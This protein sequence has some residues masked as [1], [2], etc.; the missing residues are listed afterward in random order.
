MNNKPI[1]Y[2]DMDGVIADYDE[3]IRIITG[4]K[5]DISKKLPREELSKL[6]ITN[7]FFTN[8]PLLPNA[9]N[10][11]SFAKQ[12][13]GSYQILSAP[14]HLDQ[15]KGARE[16]KIWI[17]NFL[18]T[19]PPE[20]ATFDRDK[21]K[22]AVQEDGTP[23]VLID[24]WDYNINLW[25]QHGGIGVLYKDSN[26]ESAKKEIVSAYKKAEQTKE[27]KKQTQE[28]ILR[29]HKKTLTSEQVINYVKNIHRNYK[30]ISPIKKYS[31][32]ILGEVKLSDLSN[33]EF[34]ELDDPYGR[35]IRIN[36][37]HVNSLDPSFL[38]PIVIDNRGFVLDG[39]HRVARAH[40]EGFNKIT[41]IRPK[42]MTEDKNKIDPT[43]AL[44]CK[45][46]APLMQM[47]MIVTWKHDEIDD[48]DYDVALVYCVNPKS[49]KAYCEDGVHNSE[50][51]LLHNFQHFSAV[52]LS[53]ADLQDEIRKGN[54]QSINRENLDVMEEKARKMLG[55]DVKENKND[56][57]ES[58]EFIIEGGNVFKTAEG[59]LTQ[60]IDRADIKPT[61]VFLE[62]L[63]GLPL[64]NNILG[65]VGK[66]AS[67]GDIDVGVDASSVSKDQLA[68][69]LMVWVKK[70]HPEDAPR[71]WV[72]KSGDSV[73]F[74]TP[75]AG[76]ESKGYVQTD[77]MFTDD[78]VFQKFSMASEGDK[79]AYSGM[80]RNVLLASIAKARGMKWSYKAGL[81]NRETGE[82]ISKDPIKIAVLLLGKGAHPEQLVSVETIIN[83]IKNDPQ[84]GALIADA[85]DTF[86]KSGKSLGESKYTDILRNKVKLNELNMAPGRLKKHISTVGSKFTAGFEAECIFRGL[87][88]DGDYSNDEYE[89]DMDYNENIHQNIDW[90]DIRNFFE[91]GQRDRQL[92]RMQ[93]K[94]MEFHTDKE[95]EYISD[96][97]TDKMDELASDYNY[98]KEEEDYLQPDDFEQE[99]REELETAFYDD[100]EEPSL[101]DWL[102][103]E[104]GLRDWDD[105]STEFGIDWPHY[106]SM[107]IEG[108]YSAR[109]AK[110]VAGRLEEE[111]GLPAQVNDDY[112]GGRYDGKF[113]IEPDSSINPDDSDDMGCEI[114]S[115]PLPLPETLDLMH[116]TLQ[117]INKNDG[118]TNQSTGLH[119]N[120]SI[121]GMQLDYVKLAL[122]LGD[123]HVL[124]QFGRE[125]NTYTAA[126]I[127]KIQKIIAD[128]SNNS[129][130]LFSASVIDYL[131]RGLAK[132]A[133]SA[134]LAANSEKYTSVNFH[135]DK[136]YVEFRSMGG[137]YTYRW[138]EIHDTI[139]RFARALE[140]AADPEAYKKEYSAKLYKLLMANTSDQEKDI[141]AGF[142]MAHTGEISKEH[143]KN[144]LRRRAMQRWDQ[145]NLNGVPAPKKPNLPK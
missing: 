71:Q 61:L 47:K 56:I 16:K 122:F 73:H 130:S 89:R 68:Q 139:L 116:K 17:D 67:S 144:I 135:Q 62:K 134:I 137:E 64:M 120:L 92:E 136:N 32:W 36:F 15:A 30:L 42:I 45:R 78:M 128:R 129:M 94:F 77:F 11:I 133:G 115:P 55:L 111:T 66:K 76:K 37:E 59:P 88:G 104:L 126:A 145:K 84:F 38:K 19:N 13:A 86:A 103:H 2:I 50:S 91:L 119:F 102:R 117:M 65:S 27:E 142:S 75:I 83:A 81:T 123:E 106:R 25:N 90:D 114:V 107:N 72:A 28:S 82:S 113:A 21:Y 118:Y 49:G 22:Y 6:S 58:K 125:T 69:S 74:R 63:T 131:E 96:N 52:K 127:N 105:V 54:I 138:P 51:E 43:F 140:V 101:Y 44:A 141:I 124:K 8:I 143:F 112:H 100:G 57:T 60:R 14:P 48:D 31:E 95:A 24:D 85:K 10:L 93:E 99:A 12:I 46:L 40:M 23:N 109:N 34:R 4:I 39:N 3:Q 20:H 132:A 1:I 35:K 33:P 9:Q 41:A 110:W 26:F 121:E 98:D 7:D 87:A 108:G 18:T 97:L 29:D 80:D 79:S 53:L 70:V 5:G